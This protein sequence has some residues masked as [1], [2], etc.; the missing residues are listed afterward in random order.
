MCNAAGEAVGS[1]SGEINLVDFGI[2][3]PVAKSNAMTIN[4]IK[5][6][7]RKSWLVLARESAIMTKIKRKQAR[8]CAE[9]PVKP[10]TATPD[11]KGISIRTKGDCFQAGIDLYT[12]PE[13][14][15]L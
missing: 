11:A 10:D 5:Y 6:F 2:F 4:P 1:T 3:K 8:K 12:I 7:Q 14:N 13:A 15:V 9:M